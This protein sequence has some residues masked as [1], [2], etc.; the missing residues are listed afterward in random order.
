M[1]AGMLEV[2]IEIDI[3]H[4]KNKLWGISEI[5]SLLWF[6]VYITST[7]SSL[8]SAILGFRVFVCVAAASLNKIM[9][10]F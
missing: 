5:S 6:A 1:W 8:V 3:I 10:H 7:I 2:I 4:I 9:I